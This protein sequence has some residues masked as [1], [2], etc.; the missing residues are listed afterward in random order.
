M[1]SRAA[2]GGR[3]RRR[4]AW[5]PLVLPALLAIFA[6]LA[7]V[8]SLATPIFEGP[9]EIWHFA[10]AN[11]LADSRG[12]A[13]PVLSATHP[14]LLLRN[15][16]HPPL[17][18]Y[19]VAALIAPIDRSDFP[20][21][22]HFNLGS[23]SI[24]PGSHS[25]RPNLLIHGRNE[26]FPYR[27]SVL[28]VHIGRLWS[29]LLGVV[30]LAGVWVIARQ[31]APGSA[32]WLPLAVTATAAFVPQFVYG[33][34]IINN[35]AL[36]AAGGAWTLAALLALMRWRR[37]RW[38]ALSGLALG[39]T[40][41]SKIGMVAL[42]PL[43]IAA[44]ALANVDIY[45][46]GGGRPAP[47]LVRAQV[48][49]VLAAGAIVYGAA[50]ASAGWWY[51]R[52][53]M[54][55]G[56]PLAWQ[57]WQVLAG[58]GRPTP[59]VPQF[60]SDMAGLFGTFWAD[61]GLRIDRQWARVFA[62]LM[63]A[64]LAGW[65]RR[66]VRRDWAPFNVPGLLLAGTAFALLLASAVRYSLQIT[67]IHGRLLY[68]ALGMVAFVVVAG[69]MGWGDRLGRI[70]V[71][72]VV[73]GF[74]TTAAL[75]PFLVIGPAYARPVLAAS[76][77]PGDITQTSQAFGGQVALIGYRLLTPRLQSGQ[78]A[79]LVTYWRPLTPGAP[80]GDLH[81][82]V[83]L[84]QPDGKALGH[85]EVLLGTSLY[86]SSEWVSTDIIVS[87]I[88]LT[89]T[90][91]DRPVVAAIWLSVR[92]GSLDPLPLSS[93]GATGSQLVLGRVALAGPSGC[94]AAMAANADFG[95]QMR[96]VGYT[97]ASDGLTLCWWAEAAMTVDYTVF[98]HITQANG[99]G[100]GAAD[101]QPRGGLYPTSSWLPGEVITDVHPWA[102]PAGAS[103]RVG[104]Y[105][106]DTGERLS[107]AGGDTTELNLT[108]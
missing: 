21:L 51:V 55:Y 38:A 66:L 10:F 34:A 104:V 102:L 56:D 76:A 79:H 71:A 6:G 67:N 44:L 18:F 91:G 93:P 32:A 72:G 77:L 62:V 57:I 42:A 19:P 89:P 16:A 54:L 105:R 103:V 82:N 60:L 64:A 95:G 9:D 108:P 52:N 73:A 75:V 41:L 85:S 27:Q 97:L 74:F 78:A 50:A 30:T 87:D 24:T 83:S 47:E 53:W 28:A 17:Y 80:N 40:L 96:L 4:A 101:G 8:Y 11:Y 29:V 14:D 84:V 68:P 20:D 46:P 86:P 59:T 81:A 100:L 45:R 94:Q 49:W 13:L 22:F 70:L 99:T 7:V 58:V 35:D 65:A 36:A 37:W 98:V 23:P 15:A 26:D 90:T 5:R 25:D 31:L 39:I 69:L 61:F 3:G 63:L 48:R 106:L 2:G 33:S 12:G 1:S 107:L 43:P 88:I 92:G